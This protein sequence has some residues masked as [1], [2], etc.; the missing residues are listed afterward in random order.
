MTDE[1]EYDED[2]Q[3]DVRVRLVLEGTACV[4]AQT[5]EEARA[6]VESG[7]FEWDNSFERTDWSV[8]GEP[9]QSYP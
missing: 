4:V 2:R 7:D 6:K 5:A 9:R 3:F 1:L 8:R